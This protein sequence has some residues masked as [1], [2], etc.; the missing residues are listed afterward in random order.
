MGKG[1]PFCSAWLA[2]RVMDAMSSI[3]EVLSD[4]MWLLAVVHDELW[5]ERKLPQIQLLTF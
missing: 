3:E 4:I 1:S 5:Y 2:N